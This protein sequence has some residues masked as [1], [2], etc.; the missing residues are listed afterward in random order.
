MG[1]VALAVVAL[2]AAAVL[3]AGGPAVADA[4]DGAAGPAIVVTLAAAPVGEVGAAEGVHLGGAAGG[5]HQAAL[6]GRVELQAL[7][8][9]AFDGR[10][11]VSQETEL[12]GRLA[13]RQ[14]QAAA[15]PTLGERA[16][17]RFA[18]QPLGNTERSQHEK[19]N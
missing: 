19:D 5:V 14:H 13:A 16:Q 12:R 2:A 18:G 15:M 8:L 7:K 17:K 11:F 6:G 9:E 1:V 4:G 3:A 10:A